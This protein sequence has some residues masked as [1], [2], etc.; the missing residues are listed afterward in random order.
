MKKNLTEDIMKNWYWAQQSDIFISSMSLILLT[1]ISEVTEV[2]D[3]L[4]EVED[5]E[6]TEEVKDT[7][8]DWRS[9]NH[10]EK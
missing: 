7:D 6:K 9:C 2:R 10:K 1:D 5:C 4:R 3:Q 8:K